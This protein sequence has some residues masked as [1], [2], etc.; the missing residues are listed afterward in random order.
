MN[1]QIQALDAQIKDL[2]GKR[3]ALIAQSEQSEDP[4]EL[5]T[6]NKQLETFNESLAILRK[7]LEALNAAQDA[8]DADDVTDTGDGS[9]E[10][11]KR[12]KAYQ[13]RK[14]ADTAQKRTSQPPKY[15]A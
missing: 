7:A 13:K 14:A 9:D 10:R 1:E 12:V 6:I 15:V 5:E 8:D 11:T 2:E 4:A 3:D